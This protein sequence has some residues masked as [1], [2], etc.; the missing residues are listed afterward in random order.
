[1]N[2][3]KFNQDFPIIIGCLRKYVAVNTTI[4]RAPGNSGM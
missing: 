2:E 4:K 3:D 1:M